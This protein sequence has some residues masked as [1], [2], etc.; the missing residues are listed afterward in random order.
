MSR[1]NLPA[2]TLADDLVW[3]VRGEN[4]IAAEIGRSEAETY[5]LIRSGKLTVR[6]PGRRTIVASRAQLRRDL[7]GDPSET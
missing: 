4:G 2:G 7:A 5:Y 6:K 3:G 1:K